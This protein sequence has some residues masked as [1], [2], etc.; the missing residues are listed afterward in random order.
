MRAQMC[1]RVLFQSMTLDHFIKAQD[2]V[3]PSVLTE[4]AAGEKRT[5]W[6]WF[7][8]PQLRALGRSDRAIR[9]G[10]AD[11]DDAREYL[12]HPILGPRLRECVALVL[13][14]PQK[15]AH[16]IFGSPD[17]IKFRSSLTLFSRAAPG[18]DGALFREALRI[19]YANEE[20]SLT[21]KLVP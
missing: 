6:M 18:D 21:V 14:H 4:L 5:H 16:D 9:Y 8:F 12:M 20:D 7:V 13:G 10:L 2:F 11:L 1:H 17:D 19:F 3:W 15:S